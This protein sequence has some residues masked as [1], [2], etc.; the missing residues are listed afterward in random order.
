[1]KKFLLTSVLM[2]F[3]VASLIAQKTVSGVVADSDGLPLPGATV[4][5]QGTNNG[6]STDFDGNYSIEV[7]E[8][9]TIEFSFVG[10]ETQSI[11]VGSSD[12][13]NVTLAAGNELEEVVLT[14]LGLE[15]RKDEDLSSTATVEVGSVQRSGESGVLQGLSGK[16]AGVNITRNAGDPGSGAYI[17][18]RGQNTINGPGSPLIILDGAPI[19]NANIGGNTGGV[20]QQSRL[21]DINPDDIESIS[22]I[23]G[24]AA[25]AVYGTG[26]A[27]GVLVINTKR[28]S[29][30]SKGWSVSAKSQFSVESVN[31]EWDKQDKWGQGYSEIWYATGTTGNGYDNGRFVQN[32]GYSYG[33]YMPNRAG[34]ANTMDLSSAYFEAASG[35]VYG[36]I[37]NGSATN[38]SGGMNDRQSYN[39]I[40][41]N[42]VFGDGYTR[43]NSVSFSYNDEGTRTY[44]SLSNLNQDGIMKGN[45]DYERTSLKL[46]NTT[47]ATDKLLFKI[48]SSYTKINSNRVQTGS[49]L[50]GLYL[51]YLRNS[52]DFDIRDYKGTG[53]RLSNGVFAVTPNSH[54]SYRLGT[55]SYR[56]FDTAS[57]AFNYRAPSYNNPLW[58]LN[59]QKNINTVDRFIFA[60]EV[61]YKFNDDLSL[62]V[63]YST[64]YFQ[65]NRVDYQPPGSAGSGNNGTWNEDRISNRLTNI[66]IFFTGS[67]DI[68]DSIGLDYVLGYQS[69]E[70]DYRR[71]SASE[72]VFT[73]PDQEFL[74][75]GNADS[76]NSTPSAYT[77]ITRQNG[78]Y[79]ILNFNFGE[80]LLLELTG[81]GEKFSTLPGAGTIF[82]PSASV[83]YKLTDIINIDAINFLKVRVSYGE[84]GVAANAYATQTVLGPG[85]ISSSWGDFHSGSLYGNPFTQSTSRGNPNLK[86]ERKS[87]TEFGIDTRLFDNKI[88]LGI[89]VY[90]NETEGGILA[91]PIAP[92]SGFSSSLQNAALITNEGVE[93]DFSAKLLQTDDLNWS[94]NGS[95]TQNKNIVEN[96]AGSAY[97]GLN[98]F[99]STSSGIAEGY[100]Y[101]VMRSGQFASTFT[102]AGFPNADP[103]KLVGAGDPNPDYRAGLGTS[104]NYKNWAL[105]AQLETSQGND[106]WNG[107]YGVMLFWGIHEETDIITTNN[108]GASIVNSAGTVIE[109]GQKFRG[110]I[111]DFGAGNVA[112]DSEWWTTNGGGFGDV[113]TQFIMDGSWVK[114][115]EVSLTY[116]FESDLVDR[117]GLDNLSLAVSG[118]NLFTWTDVEGF[119]PENNLTGASK[120]RGLEYFSNPGTRS[121]LTTLR[122]GF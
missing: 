35:K 116:D 64:D 84:V 21:N 32:T 60:P 56:T 79:G 38:A 73:N 87:E 77:E 37:A 105:T 3:T 52:P 54:R 49:N 44:V 96:L 11:T 42:A 90:N 85:G 91:L 121:I 25:A 30:D 58:T 62:A 119:D 18:I 23:K 75:P 95:Y 31:L 106:V 74:N 68:T 110:Y 97:F 101:G 24:A 78:L 1:M 94:I 100:P 22:V 6:V 59:E 47:Q 51:G 93:I 86:E 19:S 71:L 82:Y 55:G 114:L 28:G 118:R 36:T 8:G 72:A 98:G 45:S 39:D 67:Y 26:A 15:K 92:S 111:T 61:N 69:L 4:V 120:G 117:L 5:E 107:T 109:N 34:G 17:Q 112:V 41:R 43:E 14:A 7:A 50:N 83:G 63:R 104:L 113:G 16:T 89:T 48:S 2:L 81:R 29:R 12:N 57:G 122:F 65:D 70:A 40:N 53:Y 27:N 108:T 103:E 10:Y 80:N 46:N 33:D 66:N 13:I 20:V 115:R 76:V 99:T 88:S 9:A 102:S